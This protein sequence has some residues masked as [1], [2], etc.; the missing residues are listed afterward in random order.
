EIAKAILGHLLEYYDWAISFGNANVAQ[1]A[2]FNTTVLVA[3][4]GKYEWSRWLQRLR[5]T[6]RLHL[7]E[8]HAPRVAWTE[9]EEA[10]H[11]VG[12]NSELRLTIPRHWNELY[13][14]TRG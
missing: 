1:A 6:P 10:R 5:W 3:P 11:R 7:L 4:R 14:Y 9:A 12:T 13:K 2:H 8:T